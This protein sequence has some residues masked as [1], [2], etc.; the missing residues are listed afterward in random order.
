MV[1]HPERCLAVATPESRPEPCCAHVTRIRDTSS[2]VE[3]LAVGASP[4]HEG[5]PSQRVH[6]R[7][8]SNLRARSPALA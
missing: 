1:H 7:A 3:A 2:Q 6:T 8:M 5:L 4:A